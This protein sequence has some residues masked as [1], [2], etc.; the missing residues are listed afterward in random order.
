MK[1]LLLTAG[2]VSIVLGLA[3]A[4]V[5]GDGRDGLTATH[6]AAPAGSLT[7]TAASQSHSE[8]PRSFAAKPGTTKDIGRFVLRGGR[9]LRLRTYETA[10]GMSCLEDREGT[11]GPGATCA[12]GGLLRGRRA[13]YSITFDGG[14][15]RF[16][17][18][19][20][21]GL[22]APGIGSVAVQMT[23]GSV[24]RAALSPE[25]AFVVESSAAELAQDVVPS[26]L[27]LYGLSGRLVERIEIPTQR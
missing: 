1:R 9:E 21:L 19:Y 14:P 18:L 25:R 4:V 11:S 20:L 17:R 26:A 16:A 15:A 22:A 10:D 2:A 6:T 23:D 8:A 24:V 5:T 13:V 7:S 27:L 3:Y 12:E